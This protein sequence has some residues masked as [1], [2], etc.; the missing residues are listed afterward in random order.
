MGDPDL[1]IHGINSVEDAQPGEITFV[2]GPQYYKK[3][4]STHASA[5]LSEKIIK[6]LQKTFLLVEN[7]RY[8]LAEVLYLF[9]PT[10][11][12]FP[13]VDPRAMIG[14]HVLL[15]QGVSL[16]PYVVIED[17]VKIG[18]QVRID[19]GVFIGEGSEI[20]DQSILYANVTL[21]ERTQIGRRVIIHSG[22][23][24]GADGFGFTTYEERHVKIPQ[25]GTVT[26]EDDVELG[27]NV[28]VD[29]ATMGQTII[30]CGTKIDNHVHIGHNVKIG[31]HTIMVAQGGVAGSAKIGHHV[32]LGGQVGV[33][34]RV[35]IGDYAVIGTRSIVTRDIGPKARVS[36]FPPLP[37]KTWLLAQASLQYLPA[38]RDEVRALRKK[39]NLLEKTLTELKA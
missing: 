15:G 3:A 5:I 9:H 32:T 36:G 27:A 8:A 31:P 39:I 22:T 18:N 21:Y 14:K 2:S 20:G 23:V 28:T 16:G 29:R 19:P 25:V 37:H 34:D 11:H 12:R 6:G 13:K 7:P 35:Q 30:G 1:R 26:I 10:R 17:H 24:I 4:M 33:V 38:L